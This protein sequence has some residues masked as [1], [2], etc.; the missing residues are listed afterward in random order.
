MLFIYIM[1]QYAILKNFHRIAVSLLFCLFLFLLSACGRH[2]DAVYA[3]KS[4]IDLVA[5]AY[6][7]ERLTLMEELTSRLATRNQKSWQAYISSRIAAGSA[8]RPPPRQFVSRA[9]FKKNTE[10]LQLYFDENY[11]GDGVFA[12]MIGLSTMI[13]RA[14]N[15]QDDFFNFDSLIQQKPYNSAR[16]IEILV[17]RLSHKRNSHN[18][19]F[20]LTNE[21]TDNTMN[22]SYERLFDKMIAIEDM[23]A[24]IVA[25]RTNRAINH[26]VHT[27]ASAAF[28][29]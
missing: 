11:T 22:L 23:M 18:E 16:N 5:D 13:R 2:T 14:Y 29:A 25:D 3:A 21:Q 12:P 10:A 4:D 9:Q 28:L 15:N 27:A 6:L 19:P 8:F 26:V 1:H 17:W 20:L 7:Q 24:G